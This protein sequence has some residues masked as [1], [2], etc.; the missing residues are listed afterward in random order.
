ME[1][2]LEMLFLSLNNANVEFAK[3][4]KKF[5]WRSY[6]LAKVLL[7]TRKVEIINKK[8]FVRAA[9]NENSETFV[10]NFVVL[11]VPTAILVYLLRA[12][13]IAA[14]QWDRASTKVSAKYSNYADVFS[15]D[16]TMELPENTSMNKHGIK[17]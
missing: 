16:F 10:M 6:D 4:P 13:Q 9:L 11:E 2:I 5:I 1:L 15:F 17:L 8:E 14:L 7:T 3:K 12:A